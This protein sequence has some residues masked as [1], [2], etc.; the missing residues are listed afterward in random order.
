MRVFGLLQ[1]L[2]GDFRSYDV[3]SSHLRSRDVI[4]C[5]V[6]AS[7]CELQPCRKWNALYTQDFVLLQPL[8]G[9]FRWND[10]TSGSLSVTWGHVTAFPVTWL[11]A[12][13][14]Y[15]LVESETDDIHQSSAC[16][17]Y[18]QV[19]SGEIKSL[20]GHFRSAEVTWRHFLPL[21]CRPLLATA[22]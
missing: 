14:S 4:S 22:L 17:S 13:G 3:T 7:S 2:P 12:P 15:S 16:C 11:P 21:E 20:P 8:P 6:K 1:P 9:E 10:V 5:H 19:T 18:F